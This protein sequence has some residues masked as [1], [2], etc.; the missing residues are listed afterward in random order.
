MKSCSISQWNDASVVSK[1]QLLKDVVGKEAIFCNLSDR[2]DADVLNAAGPN[3]K[4]V[5]TMSVG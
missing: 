1:D 2:I 3:L 5:A 4:V